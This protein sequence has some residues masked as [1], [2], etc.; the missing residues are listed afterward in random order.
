MPPKMENWGND[1][2]RAF[3]QGSGL[4]MFNFTV[5]LQFSEGTDTIA[6]RNAAII[7]MDSK[8]RAPARFDQLLRPNL[9]LL[10]PSLWSFRP[11]V[12]VPP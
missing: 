1:Q 5:L 12:S 4:L 9:I 3:L 6:I 2:P 10:L 7:L 8:I 11:N